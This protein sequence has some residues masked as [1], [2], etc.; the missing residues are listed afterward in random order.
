M[1]G[2]TQLYSPLGI[3]VDPDCSPHGNLGHSPQTTI[4]QQRTQTN[5]WP[6]TWRCGFLCRQSKKKKVCSTAA[7]CT[8][9]TP[10]RVVWA[11]NRRRA[12]AAPR[13]P[14]PSP[15]RA[16]GSLSRL[17]NKCLP[18]PS[19]PRSRSPPLPHLLVMSIKWRWWSLVFPF[20][21]TLARESCS[22]PTSPTCKCFRRKWPPCITRPRLVPEIPCW[23]DLLLQ[24]TSPPMLTPTPMFS[25]GPIYPSLISSPCPTNS[26]CPPRRMAPLPIQQ[27]YPSRV[28]PCRTFHIWSV[29]KRRLFGPS[30]PNSPVPRRN[31]LASAAIECR[32][33]RRTSITQCSRT[34][35]VLRPCRPG[36][37]T[38]ARRSKHVT[39]RV[40]W[41]RQRHPTPITRLGRRPRTRA[42]HFPG[43]TGPCWICNVPES[44]SRCD[45]R[46][47]TRA[48]PRLRLWRHN[49]W[50]RSSNR[51]ISMASVNGRPGVFST[52][53][54]SALPR[55]TTYLGVAEIR[56][57]RHHRPQ[58][59]CPVRCRTQPTQ[60][61]AEVCRAISPVSCGL[62]VY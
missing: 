60:V 42:T 23:P 2:P 22:S 21:P 26:I 13:A 31:V 5:I 4:P 57:P 58:V 40:R 53:P 37:M 46:I 61:W 38:L 7:I 49:R 39:P 10:K 11:T 44:D 43:Q 18:L 17:R 50:S 12:M 33:G 32:P 51:S 59:P 28:S 25:R 1:V 9:T 62:F 48:E 30:G 35:P 55:A 41:R 45:R 3:C 14:V 19:F 24:E 56:H 47:S 15:V 52:H 27:T 20:T 29:P 6:I 8:E 34:C 16:L 36:A 54:W